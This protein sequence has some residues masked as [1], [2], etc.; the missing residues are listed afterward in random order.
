[1]MKVESWAIPPVPQRRL[2][3]GPELVYLKYTK[4]GIPRY[5]AVRLEAVSGN[6][7]PTAVAIKRICD[8]AL[9]DIEVIEAP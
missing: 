8:E 3:D 9:R 1:M 5:A 7:I 6:P 4:G 2:G